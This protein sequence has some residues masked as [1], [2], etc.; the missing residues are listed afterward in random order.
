V[1][2]FLL[3]IASLTTFPPPF[4]DEGF[5]GAYGLGYAQTG[6]F[7]SPAIPM[8]GPFENGNAW[9]PRLSAAI[10]GVFGVVGGHWLASARAVSFIFVWGAV[11]LWYFISLELGVSGVLGA[12]LFAS[13]ERITYAAHVFR[14]EAITVLLN[15]ALVYLIVRQGARPVSVKDSFQR[16]L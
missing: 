4:D 7:A 5:Y 8:V 16:G 13:A 3:S 6:K 15:S 12:L 14:P 11:A 2:L 9:N 1:L 10:F